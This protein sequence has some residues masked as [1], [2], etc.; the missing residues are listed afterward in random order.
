[1]MR[2]LTNDVTLR[3]LGGFGLGCL[4]MV[5]GVQDLLHAAF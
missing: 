5:A 1:M 4:M 3:L 2:I